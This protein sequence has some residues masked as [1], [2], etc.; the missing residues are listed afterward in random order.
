M[1][2][3]A[4]YALL[5]PGVV[6]RDVRLQIDGQRISA[7]QSG[8]VPGAPQP[9]HDF[10]LAL[11]TPGLVNAHAHL[12]L[13]FCRGRVPYRGSFIRWLQDVRDLKQELPDTATTF[14]RETLAALRAG[15]CTTVL[16]HH[17]INLNWDAVAGMGLR[18]L[19]FREF[20]MFNNHRPDLERMR[21]QAKLSYAPHSSYTAS[22]EVAEACRTLADAAGLPISV[23]LSE[24]PAELEFI[25]SGHNPDV[26]RLLEMAGATDSAWHG[27]RMSPIALF[28]KHGVLS[29]PTYLIHGNYLEPGDMELLSE[30]K[31]TIVYC[32]H[33]HAFFQHP[34]H[35]LASYLAAGI[36][37]ALGTDS[38]AS[39]AALSPL[40]EAALARQRLPEVAAADLFAAITV[41]GLQPLGWD[42]YLGRLE[43]GYLADFAVFTLPADPGAD[44]GALFDALLATQRCA[45]T[46]CGGKVIHGSLRDAVAA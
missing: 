24:F 8:Y 35:P 28:A 36:N 25:R 30:L 42:K 15:G 33:S 37:V 44:F 41:R 27:A 31:P 32:P 20:F 40:R 5:G 3:R 2:L 11:I 14:P 13:E 23:H 18:Y 12:E 22:I 46:V 4:R 10:G 29:A 38:L 16:D 43:P 9:D 45:M 26:E 19:P 7:I 34:Q 39:N 17:T 1:I 6:R 21:A